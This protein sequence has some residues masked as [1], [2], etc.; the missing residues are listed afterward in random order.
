[1]KKMK[2]LDA[3]IREVEERIAVE[4][5]ALGDAIN[6]CTQSLRTAVTSP[7]SLVTVLG[8]GFAAGKVMFKNGKATELKPAAAKTGLLGLVAG[9]AL[10]LFRARSGIGGVAG[11]A[12]RKWYA[13][14]NAAKHALSA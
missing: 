11:W 5:A 10:T 7:K 6:G 4:R 1:M 8:L 13:R 9:T 2:D 3:E 14:R 12:A